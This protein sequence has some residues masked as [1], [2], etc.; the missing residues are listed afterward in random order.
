MQM[1]RI[2]SAN[3][4]NKMKICNIVEMIQG[5]W[6]LEAASQISN[7]SSGA[8]KRDK[9]TGAMFEKVSI[10]EHFSKS[11]SFVLVAKG[12]SSAGL[13]KDLIHIG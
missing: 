12:M 4:G 9:K 7:G 11:F 3:I 5:C 6:I 13:K 1:R 8:I 10:K 2:L